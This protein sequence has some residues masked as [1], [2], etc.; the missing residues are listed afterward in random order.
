MAGTVFSFGPERSHNRPNGFHA[1]PAKRTEIVKGFNQGTIDGRTRQLEFR[2]IVATSQSAAAPAAQTVRH[3]GGTNPHCHC[4]TQQYRVGLC[5]RLLGNRDAVSNARKRTLIF[6]GDRRK[7]RPWNQRPPLP[8]LPFE[9][10][11]E[12]LGSWVGSKSRSL[13]GLLNT[14]MSRSAFA[15]ETSPRG[16]WLSASFPK[17]ELPLATSAWRDGFSEHAHELLGLRILAFAARR[18]A[19][20]AFFERRTAFGDTRL[21][22]V[23]QKHRGAHNWAG[24]RRA[25]PP[26]RYSRRGSALLSAPYSLRAG[27]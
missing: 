18:W 8:P 4:G 24:Y 15:S 22:W 17:S 1:A 9:K 27:R 23:F 25:G 12:L 11:W 20:R 10:L 7:A 16:V 6:T 19:F 5:A 3:G 14:R 21:L 26:V 13:D 2:L